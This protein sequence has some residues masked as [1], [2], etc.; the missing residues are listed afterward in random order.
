M[1]GRYWKVFP[2]ALLLLSILSPLGAQQKQGLEWITVQ[3][4]WLHQ[5]QFAGY[6]AA[7]EKGFYRDA[8][9]EVVLQP[10]QKAYTPVDA[11]LSNRAHYGVDNS[12]VLLRRLQGAPL[13]MLAPVAQ[14]SPSILIARHG[15]TVPHQLV[16]R[17][18]MVLGGKSQEAEFLAM[19]KNE[20]VPLDRIRMV[21]SS[22]N[23]DDFVQG[24]VDAFN[25]YI[26]NEPYLLKKMQIPFSVIKPVQYGIDFY[27]DILFTSEYELRNHPDRVRRFRDASLKGWQ[28]A[29]DNPEEMIRIIRKKYA[30]DRTVEHLRYEY[31]EMRK[32]INPSVISIGHINPGR[33]QHMAK[34]LEQLGLVAPGWDLTGFVYRPD[35][36]GLSGKTLLAVKVLGVSLVLALIAGFLLWLFNRKLH[37][38]VQRR[39]AVEE[40]LQLAFEAANEGLW[41]WDLSSGTLYFSPRWYTMLGYA[42]EQLPPSYDTWI[43]LIHPDESRAVSADQLARIRNGENRFQMEFRMKHADGSYRWILSR[44]QAVSRDESGAVLRLVGTHMDITEL[45]EIQQAMKLAREQAENANRIK[46]QFLANMSHEIRTPMNA[47]LG[48]AELLWEDLKEEPRHREALDAIMNSGRLLLRLIND[49]LDLSKIEAGRM[50]LELHECRLPRL[51]QEIRDMFRWKVAEKKLDLVLELDPKLPEQVMIDDVRLRQV[52]VNLTGNAVK[53]THQGRITVRCLVD[54]AY[55][56]GT[57]D[58]LLSVEDSGIGIPEQDMGRI[59]D[60]FSQASGQSSGSYGGTGL[61]LTISR[62]VVEMMQGTISVSS[63]PGQGTLFQIWLPGVE[64][65]RQAQEDGVA[66]KE[67]PPE[68]SA[69]LLLLAG[70]DFDELKEYRDWLIAILPDWEFVFADTALACLQHLEKAATAVAVVDARL[71]DE[72]GEQLCR[73]I[74]NS[75]NSVRVVLLY[76]T[77]D[78]RAE[79]ICRRSGADR[80][81]IKPL[82][83]SELQQTVRQVIRVVPESIM[84]GDVAGELLRQWQE[85]REGFVITRIPDFLGQLRGVPALPRSL[86]DWSREVQELLDKFDLEGLAARFGQ[87]PLAGIAD[88]PQNA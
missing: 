42:Y 69:P 66:G 73:R 24:R 14:H 79:L 53:F 83:R 70:D 81:L 74:K 18:V 78:A 23:L 80:V 16:D 34:T 38:E 11:V 29:L 1:S 61:G 32:L 54:R 39:A 9:L 48:F 75:G 35:R 58:L 59:F 71:H 51:F 45:K 85:I 28:W 77:P 40:Q 19:F 55:P 41:D 33:L 17:K 86:L 43:S 12:A 6:Y 50:E 67:A 82:G 20:G 46:S 21:P 65:L 76:D 62:R 27:S 15:Y 44:G 7:V 25:A 63:R 60:A 49:V 72:D 57:I 84:D 36:S 3:L 87:F 13:V 68:Q 10:G 56:D 31:L 47:V 37:L 22:L 4:R 30:P 64:V 52:L 2:W 26:C 5:F 88:A 8:G